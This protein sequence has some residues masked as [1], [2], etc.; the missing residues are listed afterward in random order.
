VSNRADLVSVGNALKDGKQGW[1]VGLFVPSSSPLVRQQAVEIKW[2][3]HAK[4]ERRSPFVQWSE[5]TTISVLVN[6]SF[7]VRI[8]LPD[9][10]QEII[11]SAPGD[12]VAYGSSVEH[13]WEALEDC[14]VV[15][16]RFPS[17]D[18]V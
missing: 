15:T 16:V 4:G 9:G 3:Q 12:F 2:G 11:L 14:T 7:V 8:K 17:F 1:F 6:G 13:S 10:M 18:R 5:T